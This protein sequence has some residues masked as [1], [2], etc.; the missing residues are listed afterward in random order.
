MDSRSYVWNHTRSQNK[1]DK[2]YTLFQTKTAQRPYP[3]GRHIPTWLFN[4]REYPP[5]DFTNDRW[6]ISEMNA[7]NLMRREDI[8]TSLWLQKWQ[9]IE[10]LN[11]IRWVFQY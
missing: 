9:F 8:L 11:R 7:I 4:I 5:R 2:V 1:L 10:T 3:L 6:Q